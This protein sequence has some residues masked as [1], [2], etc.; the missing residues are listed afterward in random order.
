MQL[1]RGHPRDDYR[2]FLQLAAHTI[3]LRCSAAIRKPGVLHKARWMAQVI[4]TIKTELL[5][6]GNESVI[7]LTARELQGIQWFVVNVYIQSSFSSRNASDAPVDDI[8]LLQRLD[9]YDDA[10]LQTA[11]LKMIQCHLRYLSQELATVCLFATCLSCEEKQQLVSALLA[12][13]SLLTT[14]I[15]HHNK[16]KINHSVA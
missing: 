4:Y 13:E 8:R 1:E 6:D 11:D 16:H 3:V 15:K 2:E 9:N 12:G 14:N 10:A 7:N 5:F